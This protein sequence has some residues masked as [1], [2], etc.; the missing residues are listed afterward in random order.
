[1]A[2]LGYT[3]DY[4]QPEED[5]SIVP[6]GE[7][8][9]II[10]S[11]DYAPNKQNTGM[12]LKLTWSILDGEMKG[13]KIFENLNLQHENAQAVIIAQKALNSICMAVG[14]QH[15][16]DSSQLHGI[17]VILDVAVKDDKT[18]GPQNRIKKHLPASRSQTASV[19][20]QAQQQGVPSSAGGGFTPP[21][22]QGAPV[23]QQGQAKPQP[24]DKKLK[25]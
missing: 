9:A 3:A 4:S 10:E 14:L 13:R 23:G 21:P 16:Q 17:P 1:M 7:Y 11:S 25:V 24:W 6:A 18:Y 19:S 2:Q 8:I 5:F 15:I 20:G 12:M 22:A